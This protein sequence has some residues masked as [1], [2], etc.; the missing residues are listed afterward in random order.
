M[1][2]R[3]F[4]SHIL[5]ACT[6][7]LLSFII[8]SLTKRCAVSNVPSESPKEEKKEHPDFT[9]FEAEISTKGICPVTKYSR[10][11]KVRNIIGGR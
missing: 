6:S 7:E 4:D 5:C 11:G 3:K 8:V 9:K 2:V 1:V 10:S